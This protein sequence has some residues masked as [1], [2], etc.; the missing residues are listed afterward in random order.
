MHPGQYCFADELSARN[1]DRELKSQPLPDGSLPIVL[2]A[3]P[4]PKTRTRL[5]SDLIRL[6]HGQALKPKCDIVTSEIQTREILRAAAEDGNAH[7]GKPYVW[8]LSERYQ[9]MTL[10]IFA[11]QNSPVR[12]YC[13][14]PHAS[15]PPTS[16]SISRLSRIIVLSA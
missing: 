10:A 4:N 14:Y 8:L 9:S 5:I 3:G 7:D 16:P 15:K 12:I 2:V 13:S 1:Y 6:H 11:A